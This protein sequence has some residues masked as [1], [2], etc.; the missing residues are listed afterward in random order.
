MYSLTPKDADDIIEPA[1]WEE[2]MENDRMLDQAIASTPT[3]RDSQEIA[4]Q[5]IPFN[6]A[7]QQNL[8]LREK[9]LKLDHHKE[10]LRK[11]GGAGMIPTGLK[12]HHKVQIMK[13]PT[14]DRTR[15]AMR[16]IYNT[17]EKEVVRMLIEH[18]QKAELETENQLEVVERAIQFHLRHG[19]PV[20]K[21]AY[22]NFLK[23]IEMM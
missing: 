15:K 21:P 11:C 4:E 16:N 18:Y 6:Q 14:S 22:T 10:F 20:N 7:L 19:T 17:A 9:L 13:S 12:I 23:K 5:H 8:K 2:A 3:R 1:Q